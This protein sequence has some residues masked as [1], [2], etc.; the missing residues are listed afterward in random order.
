VRERYANALFVA[1]QTR[2]AVAIA[3]LQFV[4]GIRLLKIRRSPASV[5]DE[6]PKQ[7]SRGSPG[8]N[9]SKDEGANVA[10]DNARSPQVRTFAFTL[11]S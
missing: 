10:H 3:P 11:M 5:A 6:Q 4:D 2:S 9:H 8:R 7:H 1:Q